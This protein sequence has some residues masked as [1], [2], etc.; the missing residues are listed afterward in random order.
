MG[1]AE[2]GEEGPGL[3]SRLRPQPRLGEDLGFYPKWWEAIG[4]VRMGKGQIC[5]VI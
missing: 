1:E 5:F 3:A 2:L 4:W